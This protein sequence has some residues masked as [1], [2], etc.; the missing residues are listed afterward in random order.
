VRIRHLGPRPD[1]APLRRAVI[2]PNRVRPT[3]LAD[4]EL[5]IRVRSRSPRSPAG[6][7]RALLRCIGP[8]GC[9]TCTGGPR[10]SGAIQYHSQLHQV[11]LVGSGS[12]TLRRVPSPSRRAIRVRA[13]PNVTC[14]LVGDHRGRV[15]A[16]TSSSQ[17]GE[18]GSGPT[19]PRAYPRRAAVS[20]SGTPPR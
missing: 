3:A 12:L 17:A 15:T 4:D 1:A 18:S 6:R 8:R 5:V 16:P 11:W 13:C 14:A 20:A 10:P 9:T 19:P 2:A 7:T